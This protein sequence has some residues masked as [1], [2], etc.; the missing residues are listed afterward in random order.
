[1]NAQ[2]F[3]AGCKVCA[4][5]TDAV[6]DG[7]LKVKGFN[8]LRVVDS[9]TIPDIPAFVGTASSVYMLA[10]FMAEKIIVANG[11]T[12]PATFEG[13]CGADNTCCRRHAEKH[14]KKFRGKH[15][16]EKRGESRKEGGHAQ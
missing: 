13:P 9:S 7:E 4:G 2:H 5:C 6:L 14:G 15:G 8:N 11:H 10:T 16:K 12:P 3:V 1:M